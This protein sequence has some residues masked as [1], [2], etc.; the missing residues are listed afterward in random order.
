MNSVNKGLSEK[1]DNK[2]NQTQTKTNKIEHYG[3]KKSVS[4]K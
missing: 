1:L 4:Y 3:S 2:I